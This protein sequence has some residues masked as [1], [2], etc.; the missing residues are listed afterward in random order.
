[1]AAPPACPG[2]KK[3]RRPVA[4]NL[5]FDGAG[6]PNQ[7]P[8]PCARPVLLPLPLPLAASAAVVAVRRRIACSSESVF[9]S[10][11]HAGCGVGQ[12]Q[13][14]HHH[15]HAPAVMLVFTCSIIAGIGRSVRPESGQGGVSL[16]KISTATAM[17]R[18]ITVFLLHFNI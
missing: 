5:P 13:S 12:R 9:T 4:R 3:L 7:I 8:L 10:A 17:L 11:E 1:M 6:Q 15:H 18:L 14:Q 16:A 2:Y